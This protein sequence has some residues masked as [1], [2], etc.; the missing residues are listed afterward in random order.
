[1]LSFLYSITIF[2]LELAY[3]YLYMLLIEVTGNYGFSLLCLSVVSSIIFGPLKHMAGALQAKEAL[4]QKVMAPQ[5]AAIRAESRGGERQARISA[6]YKR[7]GY[8]PLMA[9]RSSVGVLMQVPFLCAAYYML[10]SFA[11]IQGQSFGLIADLGRADGLLGGVNALP[12]LMTLFNIGAIY[13]TPGFSR[14][15]H[16]QAVVVAALFLALLYL[17]PSALLIYWTGNNFIMLLGNLWP[18][19]KARLPR[20]RRSASAAPAFRFL[21]A[22][23]V[24]RE[25]RLF[26]LAILAA[27]MTVTVFSPAMLYYADP[28]FFSVAFRSILADMIPYLFLWLLC[29]AVLRILLPPAFKPV[30]TFAALVIMAAAFFNSTVFTGNYGAMDSTMLAN[31]KNLD[32][33]AYLWL[34]GAILLA[35][36]LIIALVYRFRQTRK[37]MLALEATVVLLTLGGGYMCVA[38]APERPDLDPGRAVAEAR[39]FFSFSKDQ[40]NVLVL[41]LDMFTGGHV[42]DLF[43]QR[44]DLRER[45]AG[46]TWYPDTVSLGSVTTVSAPSIYGG[47][48]F[49]PDNMNARPELTLSAKFS[50][51]AAVFPR[52]FGSR[53]YDVSLLQ[54]PYLLEKDVFARAS[55]GYPV[56]IVEKPRGIPGLVPLWAQKIGMA[57]YVPTPEFSN[58]VL[59]VSV[60]RAVPH[61]LRKAVYNEGK[62]IPGSVEQLAAAKFPHVLY[63]SAVLGLMPSLADTNAAAPTMKFVYSVLPH[64]TW[65]LPP[66]SLIPVDDPEP[67]TEGQRVVVDGVFPEHMY[68]EEHVLAMLA[69]FF[70]WL[71]TNGVYDNTM[72]VLVSDHCESDSRMLNKALGVDES[73][74]RAAWQVNNAYPGRPHALLMVKDF[75]DNAPLRDN[76]ALMTSGDVVALVARAVGDPGFPMPDTGPNRERKHFIAFEWRQIEIPGK[77]TYDFRDI[78]TIKGTIFRKEDWTFREDLRM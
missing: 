65:H 8:H 15:D 67:S 58:F 1:M 29:C 6:L 70:D 62:W 19:V 12:F 36:A 11:P 31:A 14:R 50:E 78:A 24:E 18:V 48:A 34:D 4:V 40:P 74:L 57:D 66:G 51:A 69:D 23:T 61:A 75:G 32:N 10:S 33:T 35:S 22:F 42:Q 60:F 47:H 68:T 56:R 77:K 27:G 39:P 21:R 28:D 2:P 17:A 53:G 37:L 59:G 72:I 64:H 20:R 25:R 63:E 49:D 43:A 46:F 9:M 16:L 54:I 41:F 73:G 76:P 3:K 52:M 55:G 7:Y 38:Y 30:L 5:L 71:R 26:V 45:F 13:T 44:P